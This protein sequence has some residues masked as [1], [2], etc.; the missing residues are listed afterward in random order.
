ME[1]EK[2]SERRSFASPTL[3]IIVVALNLFYPAETYV[4]SLNLCLE[5]I[6]TPLENAIKQVSL[7]LSF[8][9]TL[10]LIHSL[11]S[12]FLI[13]YSTLSLPPSLFISR[14]LDRSY[15][16]STFDS[17]SPICGTFPSSTPSYSMISA[18]K[19]QG[20]ASR[21]GLDESF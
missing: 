18:K 21:V 12:S 11:C 10:S 15:Q 7:S 17:F 13:V 19:R 3:N 20:G 6:Q 8:S 1:K 16:R 9:H 14:S 2:F 4:N 5:H